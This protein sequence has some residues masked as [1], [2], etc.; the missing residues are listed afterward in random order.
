MHQVAKYY[1]FALIEMLRL[2]SVIDLSDFNL[3]VW[4]C[5]GTADFEL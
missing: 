2:F 3:G 4:A 5:V 1:C